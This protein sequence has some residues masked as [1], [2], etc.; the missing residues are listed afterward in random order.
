MRIGLV[1]LAVLLSSGCMLSGVETQMVPP[2]T[3]SGGEPAQ[4]SGPY[5]PEPHSF[6][7]LP[8]GEGRTYVAGNVLWL[9]PPGQPRTPLLEWEDRTSFLSLDPALRWVL[10]H[11]RPADPPLDPSLTL[12]PGDRKPYG[13]S[14]LVLQ[15]LP[16]GDRR[17]LIERFEDFMIDVMLSPDGH[18]LAIK[19]QLPTDDSANLY[20]MDLAADTPVPRPWLSGFKALLGSWSPDGRQMVMVNLPKAIEPYAVYVATPTDTQ[21]RRLWEAPAYPNI[22]RW[23]PD[24]E[25]LLVSW[26]TDKRA[27]VFHTATVDVASGHVEQRDIPL[28]VDPSTGMRQAEVLGVSPSG[29]EVLV[30]TLTSS[31]GEWN[32]VDLASGAVRRVAAKGTQPRWTADGAL[33]CETIGGSPVPCQ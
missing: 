13:A 32:I 12:K 5:S 6:T 31:G 27:E 18:T 4:P 28:Q 19:T 3:F 14:R 24:G 22:V 25:Q 10:L 15:P 9:E 26:S 11:E 20:L 30:F 2:G 17:V 7:D 23:K 29:D 1:A 16:R 33:V 21:P 8:N